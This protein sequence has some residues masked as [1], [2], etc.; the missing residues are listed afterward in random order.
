MKDTSSERR[1]HFAASDV[2]G[3]GG[4]V[5]M[6]YPLTLQTPRRI[7]F[8]ASDVGGLGGAFVLAT[9]RH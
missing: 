1:I 6:H 7:H 8:A 2:G 4:A 5:V 3:S 9:P